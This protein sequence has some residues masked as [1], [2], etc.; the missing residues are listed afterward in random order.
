MNVPRPIA[1]AAGPAHQASRRSVLPSEEVAV[2]GETLDVAITIKC[3]GPRQTEFSGEGRRLWLP[4]REFLLGFPHQ[5]A[6]LFE[7]G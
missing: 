4:L 7:L 1:V 3:Q 6:D 2:V 5:L